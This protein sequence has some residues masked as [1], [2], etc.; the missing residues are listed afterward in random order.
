MGENFRIYLS[1]A[2]LMKTNIVIEIMKFGRQNLLDGNVGVTIEDIFQN[3]IAK[4]LITNSENDKHKVESFIGQI[5]TDTAT[6]EGK[7]MLKVDSCF[8]LIE[9][10]ELQEARRSSKKATCFAIIAIAVSIITTGISIYYNKK[11]IASPTEVKQSQID[12]ITSSTKIIHKDMLDFK[13]K[14]SKIDSILIK[15]LNRTKK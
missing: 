5:F 2:P 13:E 3:L 9:H 4:K 8:A 12:S 11:Q 10:E 6:N 15:Y 1:Y 14:I 7:M